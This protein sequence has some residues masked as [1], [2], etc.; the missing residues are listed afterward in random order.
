MFKRLES[1]KEQIVVATTDDGSEEPIVKICEKHGIP[2]FRGSE[3]DVLHRF[4]QCAREFQTQSV[5]RLTSDCPLID[6]DIVKEVVRYFED[7]SFDYVSN[8]EE[9]SFPRGLDCEVFSAQKLFEADEKANSKF[10]REHVTPY[11][12]AHSQVGSFKDS[13]DN[14]NY[15]LTL[16]VQEDFNVIKAIYNEFKCRTDFSYKELLELLKEKPH[17]SLANQNVQQKSS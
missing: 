15:R 12:R 11:I 5:V 3:N 6:V 13:E 10:E 1:L 2:Y 8:V 7:N 14:S 16:D 4:T 17:L 9:R